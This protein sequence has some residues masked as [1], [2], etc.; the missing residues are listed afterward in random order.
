MSFFDWLSLEDAI[1]F[2]QRVGAYIW[3]SKRGYPD[4]CWDTLSCFVKMGKAQRFSANGWFLSEK[5]A[6]MY[7]VFQYG[8][9]TLLAAF[10]VPSPSLQPPRF[11]LSL[12]RTTAPGTA[13]VPDA[14]RSS[15]FHRRQIAGRQVELP[16]F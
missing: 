6:G 8:D 10:S 2:E 7:Q 9:I 4:P 14:F 12:K 11:G 13:D 16:R 5:K 3:R 1:R 15:V